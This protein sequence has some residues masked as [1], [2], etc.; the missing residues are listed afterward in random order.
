MVAKTG[1]APLDRIK[2]LLQAQNKHYK[3]LGESNHYNQISFHH[4]TNQTF[5]RNQG[6]FGQGCETGGLFCLVP[7]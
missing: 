1:V 3:H 7:W 6:S 4:L 5:L 2:I